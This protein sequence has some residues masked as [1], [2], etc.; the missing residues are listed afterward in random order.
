MAK[1]RPPQEFLQDITVV[2]DGTEPVR[3]AQPWSKDK[4]GILWAYLSRYAKACQRA[5]AFYFVDAMAGPG[6]YRIAGELFMGSTPIALAVRPEFAKCLAMDID[7]GNVSA[8]RRRTAAFGERAV[9]LQ[10]DCNRELI[11]AMR[12]VIPTTF[13]VFILFDPEGAELHWHTVQAAAGYRQGPR[14]SELLML[15]AT[16]FLPRMLPNSGLMEAHNVHAMN[17]VFPPDSGWERIWQG[18]EV[19]EIT[20]EE[21]RTQ[22]ADA[23][24]SWLRTS[25]KYAHV[26]QRAITR[27][28]S[29]SSV[30]HLIFASDHPAGQKIMEYVFSTMRPNEAQRLPGF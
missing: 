9:V 24:T 16:S 6:R 22:L 13:P 8:L 4:L 2:D 3:A 17:L 18:R 15:L 25:L 23:Y 21:V 19:G 29:S 20:P 7:E 26:E 14:K 27:P 11:P 5:G 30:Y 12:Q 10:G 28:G 1:R